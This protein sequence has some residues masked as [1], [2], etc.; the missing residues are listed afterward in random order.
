MRM[1]LLIHKITS[2]SHKR[3]GLYTEYAIT[4]FRNLMKLFVS[5]IKTF[6]VV[7]NLHSK[8]CFSDCLLFFPSFY[9]F[10]DPFY[11]LIFSCLSIKEMFD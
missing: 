2:S 8:N 6:S 3:S 4:N 9:H 1:A 7:F 10:S 5:I 11:S